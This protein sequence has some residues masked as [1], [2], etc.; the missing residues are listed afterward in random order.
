MVQH[1][2]DFVDSNENRGK[3]AVYRL[4]A[5]IKGARPCLMKLNDDFVD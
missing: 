5:A 1:E 3:G 4:S 2:Y